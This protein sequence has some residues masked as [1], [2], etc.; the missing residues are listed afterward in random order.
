MIIGHRGAAGLAPENTLAAIRKAIKLQV[1]GVEFDIRLTK[2]R[3]LILCHDER[4]D[5]LTGDSRLVRQVSL[6]ELRR[7]PTLSGQPLATLEQALKAAR[8]TIAM[9]EPKDPDCAAELHAVLSRFSN[10]DIR[11]T[12]F[13]HRVLFELRQLGCQLPFYPTDNLTTPD[14]I[15]T[16]SALRATGISLNYRVLNVLT[17]WRAR[18]RGLEVAIFT[19]NN[20]RWLR[21]LRLFY[22]HLLVCTDY[23]DKLL[24][25]R[26]R[27]GAS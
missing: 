1:D 20:P 7:R 11:I 27:R 16:A 19:L 15:A 22:R 9:V 21:L 13:E 2:D 26:R 18:R 4:L 25:L 8:P 24:P 10:Q 17:Y 3:Q 6:A 12:S 14:I 5:K 23:P